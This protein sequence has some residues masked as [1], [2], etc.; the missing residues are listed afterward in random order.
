MPVKQKYKTTIMSNYEQKPGNIIIFKN[1]DKT[2]DQPDY[3]GK[4]L[5]LDGHEIQISLWIKEGK[6][7][8]FMAGRIQPKF[9]KVE[10]KKLTPITEKEQLDDDLPF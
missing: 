1:K 8:K 10:G 3:T 5:G 2:G 7:G 4:G 6:D 9:V